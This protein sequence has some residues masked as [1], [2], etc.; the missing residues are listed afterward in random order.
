MYLFLAALGL[1][2]CCGLSQ[3]WEVGPPLWEV[4]RLL[5]VVSS[6]VAEDGL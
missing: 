4:Y 6:L 2:C 1:C 3:L 5:I